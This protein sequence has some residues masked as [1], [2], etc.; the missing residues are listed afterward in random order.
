MYRNST[1][2]RQQNFVPSSLTS[3]KALWMTLVTDRSPGR[4]PILDRS[5][6]PTERQFIHVSEIKVRFLNGTGVI[7]QDLKFVYCGS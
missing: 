3:R 4:P 2:E 5:A 6:I 7:L 1:E